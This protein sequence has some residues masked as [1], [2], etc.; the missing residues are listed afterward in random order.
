MGAMGGEL[1]MEVFSNEDTGTWTTV[2][3]GPSGESCIAAAGEN[4]LI[5]SGEAL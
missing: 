2:I 1:V 3:T 5:I 4:L